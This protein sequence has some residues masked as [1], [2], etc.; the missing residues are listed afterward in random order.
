MSQFSEVMHCYIFL[1]CEKNSAK[2]LIF[3]SVL[4]V[5]LNNSEK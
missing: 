1:L 2:N 3:L 5:T 4:Y